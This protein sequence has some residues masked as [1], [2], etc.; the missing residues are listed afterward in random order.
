MSASGRALNFLTVKSSQNSS[1][2]SRSSV[3]IRGSDGATGRPC[4]MLTSP[5]GST[6]SLY[7]QNTTNQIVVKEVAVGPYPVS[8]PYT[9]LSDTVL[10]TA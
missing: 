5:D 9:D 8:T 2:T 1:V 10:Q 4:L 6:W 3:I 7:L